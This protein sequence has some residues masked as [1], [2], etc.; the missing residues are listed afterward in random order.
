MVARFRLSCRQ[1]FKPFAPWFCGSSSH[2]LTLRILQAIVIHQENVFSWFLF[3]VRQSRA[4]RNGFSFENL[5]LGV[6]LILS[7]DL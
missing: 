7:Q 2:V 4:L 6:P 1:F 3:A 5:P